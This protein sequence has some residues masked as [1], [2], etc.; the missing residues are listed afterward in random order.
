[1]KPLQR[2][3][4]LAVLAAASVAFLAHSHAAAATS[5]KTFGV[6]VNVTNH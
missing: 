1:M 4:A 2:A 6:Y 3:A 5:S